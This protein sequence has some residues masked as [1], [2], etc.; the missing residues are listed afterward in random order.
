MHKRRPAS[1]GLL[2]SL[3][4]L[5]ASSVLAPSVAL[6]QEPPPP[7]PPPPPAA[8]EG[9]G[10]AYG[11]DVQGEAAANE[12]GV[13]ARGE[14]T[15]LDPY[16][17]EET[18]EDPDLQTRT[19]LED[20]ARQDEEPA[21]AFRRHLL[22][23]H[24]SL[25]ASTGL[26][27]IREASSGPVGSFR[28]ALYGGL[29]AGN[30]FLCTD[31]APCRDQNGQR[32]TGDSV[33]RTAASLTL[34]ATPLPFLEAFLG[35]HNTSTSNSLGRPQLLQVLGDAN[36]G[37]KVFTPPE[38][39]EIFAY[40]GEAEL[41]LLNGTGGVGLHGSST[42]FALRA[43]GTVDLN[44]RSNPEDRIP[45]RAHLNLGYAFDNSAN[46][47]EDLETTQ[48]PNGRGQPIERIE[49]F[50]LGI[51]RVDSFQI[52]V[53]A[54]YHIDIFRPFMEWS[55]D[56][57][58]NR[59]GHV[60]NIQGAAS[61]GDRCLGASGS[62]N[63]VPSRL[64][65]GSRIF[66]WNELAVTAAFDLATGGSSR[67][68]E[69]TTPELPYS[70]WIGVAYTVDTQPPVREEVVRSIPVTRRYLDGLV[71]DGSTGA[72]VP[73]AILRYED[74]PF[75]GMV[76]N[77]EGTF[78]SIDLPPG[79][80][81]LAIEAAD[82][83]PG[84]CEVFVPE[85][86]DPAG[87]TPSALEEADAT[88][89]ATVAENGDIVVPVECKLDPLPKVAS[90]TGVL[91]D[92][93]SGQPIA[94][95]TVKVTD[96]L[97]RE[98]EL[99]ADDSGAF[100]F[101]NVPFGRATVTAS[102]AGYLTTVV[103]FEIESRKDIEARVIMNKRPEQSNVEVTDKEVKLKRQ[104][105]FLY[106]SA[107]ILPDSMSILEEIAEAL[108][109]HPEVKRIE[110]QGHTDNTGK[111]EY[112]RPLSHRRAEAV[113]ASLVNLGVAEDRLM[114]KGYGPDKPLVPNTN[115][116]N[117]ARNRRVQLIVLERDES[118]AAAKPDYEW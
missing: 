73:D 17:E 43:L 85:S 50:G 108:K 115:T 106:D 91:I 28:L 64:S 14:A 30:G 67:F 72:P 41:S 4:G 19:P 36:L 32:I 20:E 104:V 7:P 116:A 93:A 83:K 109:A 37:V 92:A 16:Q 49:R 118:A 12:D 96:K 105:H 110:I 114:A 66:P 84:R 45:F 56:L 90:I 10:E 60:C 6:A 68:L 9:T 21:D 29:Y 27:R 26:L 5:L 88:A 53:G 112:N 25:R 111:A 77:A 95:A 76:A 75:T 101:R 107:E 31:V 46:V 39:D 55:I 100:Q 80:Y 103:H 51:S 8:N 1:Y 62:L 42:G 47:V 13:D 57:P 98:L 40:G 117:R 69:E 15:P 61:R 2:T 24:N 78:Q 3:A 102:G 86:A 82:Y 71:V 63:T 99:V 33:D 94:R 44:R 87:A 97:G 22:R 54:D 48:P 35:L 52:G 113:K 79:S 74:Q 59:T 23:A 70:V 34:S 38:M 81:V 58:V 89:V 18:V 11:W 65:V